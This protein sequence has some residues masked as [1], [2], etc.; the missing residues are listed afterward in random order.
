M[1]RRVADATYN[2]LSVDG[3]TS[4]SDTVIALA[5]GRAMKQAIRAGSSEARIFEAALHAVC[6]DLV[7]QLL[8][9]QAMTTGFAGGSS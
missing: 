8:H 1:L 9:P 4:T 7:R 2:C 5:S 3:E 6:E